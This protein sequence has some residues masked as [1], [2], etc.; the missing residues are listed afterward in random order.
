MADP[1][2]RR[3]AY[4]LK[5]PVSRDSFLTWDLNHKSFCRQN[6]DWIKFLPGGTNATWKR[7]D[8][9]DTQG[10]TIYETQM[11]VIGG[12]Q[13]RVPTEHI[14]VTAT[15]KARAALQEF[16]V[17]LGTYAPE[18]FM[19]TIINESTSYNW[20]LEKIKTTFS[21]NTKGLGFLAVGDL[22]F[23]IGDDGQ[24]YQQVYQAIKEFYCSSLLKKGDKHEGQPLDKNEPLTPLCKNFIVEKWLDTIH[25]GLKNHIRSSRGSLFT[26]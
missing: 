16:L 4:K 23:D 3:K 13:E 2:A 25:T 7:Y 10:I 20:V 9:D 19:H 12:R 8:E 11:R 14:D 24:T 5:Q 17:V 26:D 22:K 6:P 18:N 15:D 21:L 1:T